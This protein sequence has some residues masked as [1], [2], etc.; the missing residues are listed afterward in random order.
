MALFAAISIVFTRYASV[1]ID[2]GTVRL[3]FGSIPIIF[4][5]M[6]LGPLAGAFIG[7]VADL[8]GILISPQGA[9]HPGLT[10]SSALTGLIPGLVVLI[11]KNRGFLAALISNLLVYLIVSL[12]LNTLW[13]SQ[14]YGTPYLVLLPT[15]A[16]WQ[17]LITVGS[18]AIITILLK[19]LK[20]Q[21]KALN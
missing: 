3:G 10:L 18:I 8:L 1:M 9:F 12:A 4:S 17:G 13:I 20:I 6:I 21:I 14:L 7:I 11:L 19:S 15:R 2:D 5:G 16:I